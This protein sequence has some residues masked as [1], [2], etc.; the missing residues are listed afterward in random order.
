[1]PHK[2]NVKVPVRNPFAIGAAWALG[3][4]I[5]LREAYAFI[6][7]E[8]DRIVDEFNEGASPRGR[9]RRPSTTVTTAP[10]G[11]PMTRLESH[12]FDLGL[13]PAQFARIAESQGMT[14]E[15]ALDAL[16]TRRGGG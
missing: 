11:K 6:E 2:I 14:V 12:S 13:T 3:A 15:E 10:V 4:A 1:M 8:I 9:E 7:G 5:G 16:E